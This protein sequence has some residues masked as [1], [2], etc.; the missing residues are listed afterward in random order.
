MDATNPDIFE[1]VKQNIRLQHL[2][3]LQGLNLTAPLFETKPDSF[4][5]WVKRTQDS[6]AQI[7]AGVAKGESA[8]TTAK[9]KLTYEKHLGIFGGPNGSPIDFNNA[10]VA[11]MESMAMYLRYVSYCLLSRLHTDR[12][13]F[14]RQRH[15][16]GSKSSGSFS[17][18]RISPCSHPTREFR[19][20]D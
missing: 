4:D 1:T 14:Q 2:Q 10:F 11:F 15:N 9:K 12:G 20:T 16:H 7:H 6:M 5:L 13:Y 18:R 19:L 3:Q 17:S 8:V